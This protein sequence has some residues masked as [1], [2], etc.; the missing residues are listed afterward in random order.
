MYNDLMY[1]KPASEEQHPGLLQVP[2]LIL[3]IIQTWFWMKQNNFLEM[4]G[5]VLSVSVVWV[6]YLPTDWHNLVLMHWS[7][8]PCFSPVSPVQKPEDRPSFGLLFHQLLS[9]SELWRRTGNTL[10]IEIYAIFIALHISLSNAFGCICSS[11]VSYGF[12]NHILTMSPIM[13]FLLTVLTYA[14]SIH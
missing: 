11:N 3:M 4:K 5:Q 13:L 14:V 6:Q 7:T 2:V 1:I 9:L 8:A 12:Q 10:Y